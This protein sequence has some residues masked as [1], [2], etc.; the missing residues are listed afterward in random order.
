MVQ[1]YLINESRIDLFQDLS[2]LCKSENI[3][4][5][6]FITKDGEV[7]CQK[8]FLFSAFPFIKDW[9]CDQCFSS[10][11]ELSVLVPEWTK[12]DLEQALYSVYRDSN[13]DMMLHIFG[14]SNEKHYKISPDIENYIENYSLINNDEAPNFIN[15]NIDVKK[16]EDSIEGDQLEIKIEPNYNFNSQE[17]T[18][19]ELRKRWLKNDQR[20]EDCGIHIKHRQNLWRHVKNCP[21]LGKVHTKQQMDTQ[22]EEPSE[23]KE[24]N[25][26]FK[27]K[28]TLAKHRRDHH[29]TEEEKLM[30]FFHCTLCPFRC[31]E[32]TYL[33]VHVSK[34]HNVAVLSCDLCESKFSN[35]D[36]FRVHKKAKHTIRNTFQCTLCSFRFAGEKYLKVHIFK[37]HSLSTLSC[38]LCD[39]KFISKK[40]L[41]A[42]RKFKHSVSG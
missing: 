22:K 20:C 30:D 4:D 7:F 21:A 26:T 13:T 39:S 38:S 32:E 42:H 23:C 36:S 11:Q 5:V 19:E 17:N 33:K 37:T 18:N 10:H 27:L 16:E 15:T 3:C 24:C 40:N 12:Q 35:K 31:A 9:L 34:A 14:W 41:R 28:K 25:R 6:R 29:M 2:S 1:T 8:M